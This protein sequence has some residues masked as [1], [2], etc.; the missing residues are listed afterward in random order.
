MILLV[1]NITL[2]GK[3][4]DLLKNYEIKIEQNICCVNM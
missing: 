2:Y 3:T 4:P 1:Y